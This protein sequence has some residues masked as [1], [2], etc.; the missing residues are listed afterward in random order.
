MTQQPLR[1]FGMPFFG[2]A[3]TDTGHLWWYEQ[4]GKRYPLLPEHAECFDIEVR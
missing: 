4:D 1:G 3:E 2:E